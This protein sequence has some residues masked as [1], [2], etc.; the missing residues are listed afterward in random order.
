[1]KNLRK[2]LL[3]ILG[4]LTGLCLLLAVTLYVGN[5]RL[6]QRSPVIESLSD[7]DKIR[8]AEYFYIREQLGDEVWPGW[9][10]ANIPAIL[11]NEEYAFLIGYPDPP[12]GWLKVPAGIKHGMAWELVPDDLFK[13]QP[14]YR[15][16]LAD[17]DQ[18]P[19]AFTVMVGDRWVSSMPTLDWFRISLVHQ[20]QADLT[21]FVRPIF[22][23]QIFV[24]QLV[25]GSDQYISLS[26]HEAF[27]AL[28]GMTAPQKFAEAELLNQYADQYPWDDESLQ[29]DWQK[30][31]DLLADALRSTERAQTVELV[32]QFLSWR[33]ARRTRANLSPELIAFEQ[34][35]E[36]LEGLARYS[37]LEIWRQASIGDYVPAPEANSLKDFEGYV[38]FESRW[39]SELAQITRMANDDGDGRFYYTGM[40]QAFLL[41]RL[42]NGWKETAFEEGIW[43]EDVLNEAIQSAK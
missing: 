2:I 30:E 6:P 24:G 39:S 36:W 18:T 29:A 7:V 10:Q 41:D 43:L 15:Q 3:S 23:Y 32:R 14:Y 35:R 28:Q 34:N 17:P 8:L 4:I 11:Y 38:D 21:T 9:G 40:A 27:H 42:S 20:I 25:S 37:E 31:L 5:L 13:G 22:P 16:R 1:M 33:A 12:D 19:E 26:S